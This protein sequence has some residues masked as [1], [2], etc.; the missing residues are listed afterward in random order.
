M[1]ISIS[2][3]LNRGPATSKEIQSATGLNQTAV[4]RQLRQMS[5]DIVRRQGGRS[6]RYAMTNESRRISEVSWHRE[7]LSI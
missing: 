1:T 4:S 6:P 5:T 2:E 7:T 3:L